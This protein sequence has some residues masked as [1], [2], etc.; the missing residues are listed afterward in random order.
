[1]LIYYQFIKI[2]KHIYK[3]WISAQMKVQI[4][5]QFLILNIMFYTNQYFY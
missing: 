4:N 1:M 3:F 2:I 5:N